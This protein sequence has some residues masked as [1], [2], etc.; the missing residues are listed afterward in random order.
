M[1][2]VKTLG[3]VLLETLMIPASIILSRYTGDPDDRQTHLV[4]IAE[5]CHAIAAFD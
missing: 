3:Y 4:T 5:L 2:N 1:L